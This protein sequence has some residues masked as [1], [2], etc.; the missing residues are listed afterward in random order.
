MRIYMAKLT[1]KGSLGTIG[2][3]NISPCGAHPMN[4]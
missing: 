4:F 3:N 1:P 2:S